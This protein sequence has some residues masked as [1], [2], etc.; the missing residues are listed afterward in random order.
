MSS[1]KDYDA[2]IIGAGPA[3][4][5]AATALA[6]ACR[7]VAV[8]DSQEYRNEGVEEMHNVVLHDGQK[9]AS[10]RTAAVQDIS[11]KYPSV[12]FFNTAVETAGKLILATGSKDVFLDIPGYAELWGK[13]IVHCLFCDGFERRDRSAGIL[14]L[15]SLHNLPSIL[16]ARHMSSASVTI[17]LNGQSPD[18]EKDK[19]ALR[20][21]TAR[22]CKVDDRLI[23]RLSR[24]P[25]NDGI[26]VEF[27]DGAQSR[28]GYLLHHP[29]TVNRASGLISRLGL[30]LVQQ[31]VHVQ[32]NPEGETSVRGCFAAGDTATQWKIVS[33]ALADGSV[34]P[35]ATSNTRDI[36]TSQTCIQY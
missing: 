29:P 10:F 11:T 28:I 31:G 8:F 2:L 36:S 32:I 9:P 20:V 27:V 30:Q 22:G 21:A 19:E 16:M 15:E 24:D 25:A 35:A 14:G 3:G 4:L 26:I 5:A 18:N 23:R 34:L 12:R 6:R 33:V 13:S 17:F 7:R 1:P